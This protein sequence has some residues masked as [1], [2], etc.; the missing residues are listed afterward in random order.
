MRKRHAP[1]KC[2][3]NL[4]FQRGGG[5][6][7]SV[8]E[9]RL[10]GL[11]GYATEPT[12]EFALARVRGKLPQVDDLGADR[13]VFTVNAHG[14]RA[15]FQIAAA[16]SFRLKSGQE[17]RVLAVRGEARNV[18]EHAPAGGHA[19]GGNEDGAAFLHR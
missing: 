7:L 1:P 5:L 3:F 4:C 14:F 15:F 2:R 11:R 10:P 16:R 8:R 13:N 6:R 12:K 19:A 18:M 17:D 9:I